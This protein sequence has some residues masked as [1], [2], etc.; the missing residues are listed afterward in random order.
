MSNYEPNSTPGPSFPSADEIRETVQPH[1][2]RINEAAR[3]LS[4]ARPVNAVREYTRT[5]RFRRVADRVRTEVVPWAPVVLVAGG[6]VY[7]GF[8]VRGL[9]KEVVKQGDTINAILSSSLGVLSDIDE[10]VRNQADSRDF[11]RQL[12]GQ[13][14]DYYKQNNVAFDYYPGV[15]VRPHN[16]AQL[17]QR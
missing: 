14:I 6:V 10:E 8:S 2:N 12:L 3:S 13:D 16:I 4:D 5:E 17:R 15:G 1:I 7:T 11:R 9:M